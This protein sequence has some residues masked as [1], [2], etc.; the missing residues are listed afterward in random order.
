MSRSLS[1]CIKRFH[2][3]K[4]NNQNNNAQFQLAVAYVC[5]DVDF[6]LQIIEMWI[7]NNNV[8]FMAEQPTLKDKRFNLGWYSCVMLGYLVLPE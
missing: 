2:N 4:G 1:K 5:V 6:E 8:L 3:L 7:C